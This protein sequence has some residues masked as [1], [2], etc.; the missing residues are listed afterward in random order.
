MTFFSVDEYPKVR[1]WRDWDVKS[2]TLVSSVMAGECMEKAGIFNGDVGIFD[3]TVEV[4]STD[5][6]LVH[7]KT[8]R[9]DRLLYRYVKFILAAAGRWWFASSD[10]LI[11]LVDWDHI[12]L[13]RLVAL[14]HRR[15][16]LPP[17]DPELQAA[18]AAKSTPEYRDQVMQVARPAIEE[19]IRNGDFDRSSIFRQA[20]SGA[21]PALEP[22]PI[23]SP[24]ADLVQVETHKPQAKAAK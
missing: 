2:K 20:R 17:L 3:S 13:G 7:A 16:D 12:V 15:R 24:W 19:I 23:R 14:A 1:T 4:R 5:I 8:P 6:V 18:F 9:A 21:A 22:T 10:G 11:P